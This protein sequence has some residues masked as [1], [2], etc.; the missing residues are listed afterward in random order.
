MNVIRNDWWVTPVWEV[1]TDFDDKFNEQLLTEV[2]LYYT[3]K[4][5][6]NTVD[7]NIWTCDSPNILKLNKKIL[8]IVKN[9]THQYVAPNYDSFE[10]FHS[11]G[12]LN[13]NL[14][15]QDLALHGHGGSKISATYYISVPENSGDLLL[16]DP[17][18]GVDWDKE[19]EN[20]VNGIKYK[21]IKPSKGKL[22]FFPSYVLHSVEQNKSNDVRISLTTDISTVSPLTIKYFSDMIKKELQNV[23]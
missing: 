15:G 1:Q 5:G 2:N 18:G 6:M 17:R 22:I 23:V 11:K 4:E 21:R 12:W 16:V 19:V 13:Y 14:S 20:H 8:E 7:S 9:L 3:T 10:Y